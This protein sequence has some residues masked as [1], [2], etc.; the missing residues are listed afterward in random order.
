MGPQLAVLNSL[1]PVARAVK[2]RAGG[3]IYYYYYYK[4]TLS[5]HYAFL[6]I[7]LSSKQESHWGY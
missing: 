1:F 5:K 4:T 2:G 6:I 3:F 7:G